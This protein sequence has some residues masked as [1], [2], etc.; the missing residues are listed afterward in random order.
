[1]EHITPIYNFKASEKHIELQQY[2]NIENI[3]TLQQK[4]KEYWLS[5]VRFIDEFILGISINNVVYEQKEQSLSK[6]G[7][8]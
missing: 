7:L 2:I 3:E 8:L 4:K 5:S 1:M 6:L